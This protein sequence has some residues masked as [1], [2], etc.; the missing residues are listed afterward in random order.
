MPGWCEVDP[1]TADLLIG[2]NSGPVHL[3]AAVG[4]A[5]DLVDA[6]R[7]AGFDEAAALSGLAP[8]ALWFPPLIETLVAL[9]AELFPVVESGQLKIE[10]NQTYPL[11]N[12]AQ[13]HR[14][15]EG[16]KTTGSTIF[17]P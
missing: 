16:R 6:R 9:G 5:A 8:D 10:I 4:V 13:A 14:D 3:A 2:N 17:T 15:L 12:A 11:A 1:E 7:A